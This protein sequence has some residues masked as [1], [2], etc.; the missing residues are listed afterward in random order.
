MDGSH[1]VMKLEP[2]FMAPMR[3]LHFP[4]PPTR[5]HK[6]ASI[7]TQEGRVVVI[8]PDTNGDNRGKGKYAWVLPEKAGPQQDTV[9]VNFC[10]DNPQDSVVSGLY[11]IDSLCRSS[12]LPGKRTEATRRALFF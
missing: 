11:H 12:N 10:K 6:H 3:D 9:W 1:K 7:I 4:H 5:M 2:M 8:G